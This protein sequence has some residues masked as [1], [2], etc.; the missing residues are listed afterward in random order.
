MTYCKSYV[1]Y[2]IFEINFIFIFKKTFEKFYRTFWK[3]NHCK[4]ALFSAVVHVPCPMILQQSY[5]NHVTLTK[6]P[7]RMSHA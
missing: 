7:A 2:V 6:F 5:L 4:K 3:R 1:G